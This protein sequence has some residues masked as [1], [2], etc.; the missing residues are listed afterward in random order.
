M[1]ERLRRGLH[2]GNGIAWFL[3]GQVRNGDP[4]HVARLSFDGAL[5]HDAI[6]V[7]RPM[8][9]AETYAQANEVIGGGEIANFQHFLVDEIRDLFTAR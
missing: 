7:S 8:E 5:E 6:F 4:D 2:D 1:E 9:N 3:S